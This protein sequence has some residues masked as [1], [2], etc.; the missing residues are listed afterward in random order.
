MPTATE[1]PDSSITP[2]G[3]CA[4]DEPSCPRRRPSPI[5]DAA[6]SRFMTLSPI[7]GSQMAGPTRSTLGRFWDFDKRSGPL[8][9]GQKWQAG[10]VALPESPDE[11]PFLQGTRDHESRC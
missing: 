6:R 4:A 10:R 2:S 9:L 5:A 7:A 11:S 3:D 1:P 8:R